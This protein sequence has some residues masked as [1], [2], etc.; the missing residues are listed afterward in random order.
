MSRDAM[1]LVW[2]NGRNRRLNSGQQ[3]VLVKL[4][5]HHNAKTGQCNPSLKRLATD[6][7]ISRAMI[8]KH[9]SYLK[10]IG[11]IDWKTGGSK[12]NQYWFP[13]LESQTLSSN[14]VDEKDASVS[15]NTIDDTVADESDPIVQHTGPLSSSTLDPNIIEQGPSRHRDTQTSGVVDEGDPWIFAEKSKDAETESLRVREANLA[16]VNSWPKDCEHPDH[17]EPF[18]LVDSIFDGLPD[19]EPIPSDPQELVDPM[20]DADW[21]EFLSPPSS[22]IT[23]AG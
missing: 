6:L 18:Y 5:D 15:S 22:V 23:E 21:E 9:L 11:L 16:S 20:S 13:G 10:K 14:T 3:L 19:P 1:N 2:R 12:S 8:H 7:V 4:A 17:S